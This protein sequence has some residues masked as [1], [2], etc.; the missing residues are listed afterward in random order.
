MAQTPSKKCAIC[1]KL[2]ALYCY[3]CQQQLCLQCKQNKHDREAVYQDHNVV[4]IPEAG[5]R[6]FKPVPV[7]D[8]HKR[9][10]LYYCSKCDCLTCKECLFLVFV[11]I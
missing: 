2:A 9:I 4:D 11:L 6:I 3:D 7:C 10:F 8:V 1:K 5:Y